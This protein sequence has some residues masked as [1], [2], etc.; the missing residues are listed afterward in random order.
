[1]AASPKSGRRGQ[2]RLITGLEQPGGNH[3]MVAQVEPTPE[4]LATP[5]QDVLC[6]FD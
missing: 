1:M 5:Q 2:V 4:S 6:Q 3:L